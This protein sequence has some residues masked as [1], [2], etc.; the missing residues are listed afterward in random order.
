MYGFSQY[1]QYWSTSASGAN[2]YKSGN[3]EEGQTLYIHNGIRMPNYQ[4]KKAEG[5]TSAWI[6]D[7]IINNKD[8]NS[9]NSLLSD[10]NYRFWCSHNT[11]SHADMMKGKTAHDPCP[12]GYIME[13]YSWQYWYMTANAATKTKF[14][15]ARAKEDNA[16][17]YRSGYKFYGMY[18]NDGVDKANNA[19]PLYWP[20]DGSRESCVSGVSGQY[21]N[22]GYIY[23]VN[24]NNTA[25]YVIGDKTYGK[26]CAVCYGECISTYT[27]PGLMN[28]S[29]SKVVNAQAYNVR[30][31]R[32]NF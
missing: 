14:G 1:S 3:V 30:C 16:T 7:N 22:C 5:S 10:G 12:P 18:Y 20:C 8:V 29:V 27:A 21:S 25:T 24:T 11:T 9:N 6:L 15:Y 26:A 31:R 19:V 32:G 13:N 17:D 4:Y 23:G 28:E 2:V